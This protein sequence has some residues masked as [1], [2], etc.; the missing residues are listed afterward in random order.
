MF[1]S[2]V[3]KLRLFD[4]RAPAPQ[5]PIQR[6]GSCQ[7][8]LE[9]RSSRTRQQSSVGFF[10]RAW[11]KG[12]GPPPYPTMNCRLRMGHPV[13]LLSSWKTAFD[14]LCCFGVRRAQVAGKTNCFGFGFIRLTLE[15]PPVRCDSRRSQAERLR[16]PRD[17][18]AL[19]GDDG[20]A[21]AISRRRFG[22]GSRPRF[23]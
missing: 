5:V 4:S 16:S 9:W 17:G 6:P 20:P 13:F 23:G 19:L 14:Q 8:I 12:S 1:K 22:S 11:G 7:T 10:L 3:L 15:R 21:R 2:V 18:G